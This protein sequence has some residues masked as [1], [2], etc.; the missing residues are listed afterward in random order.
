MSAPKL[1]VRN[2]AI[3]GYCL[4]SW[5]EQSPDGQFGVRNGESPTNLCW[6]TDLHDPR[7]DDLE[8]WQFL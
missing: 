7:F 2:I 4:R 5:R 1:S 3:C 8:R 6:L